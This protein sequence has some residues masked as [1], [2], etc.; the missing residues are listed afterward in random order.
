MTA[1]PITHDLRGTWSA[2]VTFEKG[3][4]EGRVEFVELILEADRAIVP[5]DESV[6]HTCGRYLQPP[7]GIG[8]WAVEDDRLSYS[9]YDVLIDAAGKPTN[10]VRVR[11]QGAIEPDGHTFTAAGTG[12]VYGT[13]GELLATNQTSIRATRADQSTPG[14]GA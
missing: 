8:E 4:L 7:R 12:E 6:L 2:E 10:V 1:S 9:F 5:T 3:P 13:G 11:A 14:A